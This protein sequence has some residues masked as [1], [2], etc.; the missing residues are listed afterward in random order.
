MKKNAKHGFHIH[1]FGDLTN[2]CITAGPH[3]NPTKQTHGGPSEEVRHIGDLGNI[4]SDENGDAT[5]E[6]QDE[7]IQLMGK[8]SIIGRSCV[9]HADEDDLGKGNFMDSKTTGHSGS[10]IACGVIGLC[11]PNKNL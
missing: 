6:L 11:D 1:D 3:Y 5:Y 4:H 8:H 9:V 7:K 2:G 10:R